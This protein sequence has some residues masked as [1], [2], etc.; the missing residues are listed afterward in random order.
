MHS[1]DEN[2]A[3]GGNHLFIRP[4]PKHLLI[5]SRYCC[6]YLRHILGGALRPPYG[7]C[8]GPEARTSRATNRRL[9]TKQRSKATKRNEEAKK[10]SNTKQTSQKHIRFWTTEVLDAC[11]WIPLEKLVSPENIALD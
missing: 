3:P 10:Q 8:V 1:G 7:T 4:S 2:D 11:R 5:A 6:A 9:S